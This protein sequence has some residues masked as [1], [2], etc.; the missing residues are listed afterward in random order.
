MGRKVIDVVCVCVL[1]LG[2]MVVTKRR[3]RWDGRE[4]GERESVRGFGGTDLLLLGSGGCVGRG[5][6]VLVVGGREKGL[7][8]GEGERGGDGWTQGPDPKEKTHGWIGDCDLRG[9]IRMDGDE[10]MHLVANGG[11]VIGGFWGLQPTYLLPT[12]S[13]REEGGKGMG[14]CRRS[15]TLHFVYR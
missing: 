12:L 11:W 6:C 10:Y 9:G 15:V 8:W 14:N 7:W 5:V 1:L 3:G 13:S 4:K 2:Q